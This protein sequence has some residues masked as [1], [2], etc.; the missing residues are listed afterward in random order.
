MT[1]SIGPAA[2]VPYGRITLDTLGAGGSGSAEYGYAV[3]SAGSEVKRITVRDHGHTVQATVDSGR[4]T[5]WWP[6]RDPGGPLTGTLTL[7]L[8][9]G[10]TRTVGGKALVKHKV[11]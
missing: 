9:D 7:I 8:A 4:W 6:D 1:T 5:V 10:T 11:M 2:E 3:G